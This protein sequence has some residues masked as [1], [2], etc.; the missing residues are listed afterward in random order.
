M[1]LFSRKRYKGNMGY[2]EQ[3]S[4][5]NSIPIK[6]IGKYFLYHGLFGFCIGDALGVPVEFSTRE[7][8]RK[9][10]VREMRAYGT[11]GQPLGT[12]SDDTSLM[13]CLIDAV[14]QGYS[15]R[16]VADNF[17]RFYKNGAFTPYGEVFDIGNSTKDAVEKMCRGENPADCGGISEFENGNGSL[18]RILPLAFYGR[19]MKVPEFIS[20][21]EEI[22]S[23]THR[24]PRSRLACIF[25]VRFTMY[26]MD[27]HSFREDAKE[28][29]YDRTLMFMRKNCFEAYKDEWKH[30]DRIFSKEILYLEEDEI[31][32][33]GYVVDTLE[34]VLWAFYHAKSYQDVVLTAVNLGEDTDTVAALAG[35]LAGIFYCM[36]IEKRIPKEW[37]QN[38]VKR[39][40]L[41]QMFC[42]FHKICN[43]AIYLA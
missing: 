1:K 38:L 13:L 25:Y 18:M 27:G 17:I 31:R 33:T 20:L 2:K 11:H 12:W 32:S 40:E 21:I 29:A 34:A 14:N 8:R 9:D 43:T 22:S 35:G 42:K 28:E 7:Q 24:H 16:K 3:R 30:F 4:E 37:I 23:L 19:R 10:P 26:L 39:E 5:A 6:D 36:D 41:Y 15:I